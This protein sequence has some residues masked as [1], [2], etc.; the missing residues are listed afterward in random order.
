MRRNP[1][2]YAWIPR[3]TREVLQHNCSTYIGSPT[4]PVTVL[5]LRSL[6]LWCVLDDRE[7]SSTDH[8]C[9]SRVPGTRGCTLRVRTTQPAVILWVSHLAGTASPGGWR[10]LRRLCAFA[11]PV[12]HVREECSIVLCLE[13]CFP[14]PSCSSV[15]SMDSSPQAQGSRNVAL[16]LV[17]PRDCAGQHTLKR[18]KLST[19]MSA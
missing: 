2:A 14:K 11:A 3:N 16:L 8:A 6:S 5:I 17:Y 1:L 13:G 15:C 4:P 12:E 19:R 18:L 10:L 7:P 9:R